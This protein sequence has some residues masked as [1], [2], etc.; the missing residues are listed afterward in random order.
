MGL[1]M[2]WD[3][4]WEVALTVGLLFLADGCAP[5]AQNSATPGTVARVR[6]DYDA[7]INYCQRARSSRL[8]TLGPTIFQPISGD[9]VF[10]ECVTR[11]KANLDVEMAQVE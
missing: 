1:R 8:S 10:N 3:G 7:T 9:E 11:A 6:Q 5:I 4:G 2:A